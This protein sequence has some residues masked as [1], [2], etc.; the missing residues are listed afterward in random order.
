MLLLWKILVATPWSELG[1]FAGGAYAFSLRD[2]KQH[3]RHEIFGSGVPVAAVDEG[4]AAVEGLIVE[5]ATRF[6]Y[7][8]KSGVLL[9]LDDCG[10]R[11]VPQS[12]KTL[13]ATILAG[14]HAAVASALRDADVVKVREALFA[15]VE[16]WQGTQPAS[17]FPEA[18]PLLAHADPE[19]RA[20][21]AWA[22]GKT[23]EL[24]AIRALRFQLSDADPSVRRE[25]VRALG[26]GP[27]AGDAGVLA[28]VRKLADDS[29]PS[30][31]AAV[32]RAVA[33]L[34]KKHQ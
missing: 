4:D 5:A 14:G 32:A 11:L 24:G 33:V 20:F 7:D 9:A 3:F 21:A 29:D 18:R 1:T 34:S 28:D 10:H 26:T 8:A 23:R 13:Y 6:R 27:L 16:L 25:A 30:V 31:R 17:G 2:G 12:G 19:V 15:G 22:I